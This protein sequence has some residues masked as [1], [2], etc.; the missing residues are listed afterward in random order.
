VCPLRRDI[1][2]PLS[3]HPVRDSA[4]W[5]LYWPVLDMDLSMDQSVILGL[6]LAVNRELIQLY[7]DIGRLIVQRQQ[8]EAGVLA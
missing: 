3:R 5:A 8:A 4:Q 7:W 6:S 1:F 2:A